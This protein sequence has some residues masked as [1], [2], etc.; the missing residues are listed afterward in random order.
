MGRDHNLALLRPD[1]EE[2]Q[3]VLRIQVP[4]QAPRHAG[5]VWHQLGVL[6]RQL[7]LR[8]WRSGARDPGGERER[9]SARCSGSETEGEVQGF[10]GPSSKL[11]LGRTRGSLTSTVV[12]MG[13]P[14]LSTMMVPTMP[15]SWETRLSVSCPKSERIRAWQSRGQHPHADRGSTGLPCGC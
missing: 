15:C 1:S 12:L 6:L 3:V 4:N 2:L 8:G 7:S 5:Q 13:F 10:W 14:S 9:E 11:S